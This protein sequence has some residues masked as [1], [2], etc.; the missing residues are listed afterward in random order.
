M[1]TRRPEVEIKLFCE[2]TNSERAKDQE[3][4]EKK[5]KEKIDYLI[6][7]V[8]EV[9]ITPCLSDKS[10]KKLV[11]RF[12]KEMSN[13]GFKHSKHYNKKIYFDWLDRKEKF[14]C[15]GDEDIHDLSYN[16]FRLIHE[17]LIKKL[18]KN[19]YIFI[20]DVNF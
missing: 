1:A 2:K 12:L 20:W 7:E 19:Q 18:Q 10:M 3:K 16:R 9:I 15:P 11:G 4:I 17:I 13:D 5:Y 8:R 14:C 6:K